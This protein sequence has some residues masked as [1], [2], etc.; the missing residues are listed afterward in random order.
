MAVFKLS[1]EGTFIPK[2]GGNAE[3]AKPVRFIY[4][5]PTLAL[6]QELTPQPEFEMLFDKKGKQSG[7][8]STMEVD[9]EKIVRGMTIR[10]ENLEVELP[11]GKVKALTEANDL[12][13]VNAPAG[14]GPL[15]D[16]AAV[17]YQKLLATNEVPAKN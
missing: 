4:R 11:D 5:A 2:A 6:R 1:A 3:E 10:I 7:G 12:Y 17:F 9:N 8:R 14:V 13:G 15:V 16:E